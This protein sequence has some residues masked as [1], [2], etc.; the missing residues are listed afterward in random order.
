[1]NASATRTTPTLL[2][3]GIMFGSAFLFVK[4]LVGEMQPAQI[5]AW[6][7]LF[8]GGAVS[9]FLAA[10][11][12]LHLSRSSLAGK[13]T[14][15]ALL[16]SVVPNTLLAWAQIRIDSSMA[17]LLM[18]SMPLFTVLLAAAV[19]GRDH[20][21]A[22]KTAGLALGVAGVTL[23]VGADLRSAA[24]GA[25]APHLAVLLASLSNAAAVVYARA[26]LRSDDPMQLSAIK[27]LIGGVIA[28]AVALA[29]NGGD[30]V[31]RMGVGPWALLITLGLMT[32]GLART[33]YLWLIASAGSLRASLVAYIVPAVGVVLGW[34]VRGEH[35]GSGGA[36][37]LVLIA[38][39]VAFVTHGP[40]IIGWIEAWRL[41]RFPH[42]GR[43]AAP[44]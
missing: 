3:V 24:N 6:R 16:D 13:A 43:H 19:P 26:A 21:S 40:L 33:L 11:G 25:P 30:P 8:G 36:A 34:L 10:R 14:V 41:R 28:M 29:L 18:S 38:V 31:P 12:E 37:G 22:I 32:N 39:G 4:L 1:M 27:L 23:A 42:R 17:A 7:L 5:T 2:A 20:I 44:A 9:L 35:I 15:L